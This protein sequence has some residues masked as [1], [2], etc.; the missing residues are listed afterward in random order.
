MLKSMTGYGKALVK[1]PNCSIEVEVKSVNHKYCIVKSKLP[2]NLQSLEHKIINQ[3][4]SKLSRGSID[5][6]ISIDDSQDLK[7]F[8]INTAKMTFLI[9]ELEKIGTIFH[10]SNGITYE[11]LALFRD[12]YIEK[13]D[14]ELDLDAIWEGISSGLTQA[15]DELLEMRLREGTNLEKDIL[16]RLGKLREILHLVEGKSKNLAS[17]I[18]A[19]FEEKLEALIGKNKLEPDRVNQEIVLLVEKSDITEEI[20][21]LKS[22][23]EQSFSIIEKEEAPGRKLEFLMQE[24]LREANTIS[25]K[26]SNAGIAQMVVEIKVEIDKIREQLLNVE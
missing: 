18:R 9:D 16:F 7:P 2:M 10:F 13:K 3:V 8:V 22:H 21:R 19:N 12:Y 11:T 4:K 26:I 14:E 25:A 24:L 15:S 17:N 20:T 5:V 6:Y 23:I 1:L